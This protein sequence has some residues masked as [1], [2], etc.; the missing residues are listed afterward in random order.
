MHNEF[1]ARADQV[2]DSLNRRRSQHVKG[3]GRSD[4]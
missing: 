2:L 3:K 4:S 1:R